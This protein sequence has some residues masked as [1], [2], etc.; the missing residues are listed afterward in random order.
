MT[1]F[2]P[3]GFGKIGQELIDDSRVSIE[4]IRVYWAL[5]KTVPSGKNKCSLGQRRIGQI[6]SLSQKTVNRRINDLISWGHVIKSESRHG[7]RAEY[8]LTSVAFQCK[9]KQYRQGRSAKTPNM[10]KEIRRAASSTS[11]Q[12]CSA[13]DEILA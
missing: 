4:H 7:R 9:P 3:S 6:V 10:S 12:M 1:H 2:K 13:R 11:E 5:A 8:I